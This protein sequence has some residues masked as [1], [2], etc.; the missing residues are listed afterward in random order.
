MQLCKA[1]AVHDQEQS[2]KL[3]FA[4][5]TIPTPVNLCGRYICGTKDKTAT[6][7]LLV[8][9]V[10]VL[11]TSVGGFSRA[12]VRA[13][14][15]FHTR[16]LFFNIRTILKTPQRKHVSADKRQKI[17][18]IFFNRNT[19]LRTI[20]SSTLLQ[21][22]F[23]L[24]DAASAGPDTALFSSMESSSTSRLPGLELRQPVDGV[25]E[26]DVV[27]VIAS[28]DALVELGGQRG[29]LGLGRHERRELELGEDAAELL[30]RHG[31]VVHLVVVL[32]QREQ[33]H[34]V[35][36]NLPR[37]GQKSEQPVPRFSLALHN[38]FEFFEN[39]RMVVAVEEH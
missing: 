2:L 15:W 29:P 10:R 13:K 32:E 20:R 3:S 1:I 24:I 26:P 27:D 9:A 37:R 34:P 4:V 19:Y 6:C 12:N 36:P 17:M 38:A 7:K 14:I 35:L 5:Q 21:K 33:L 30:S 31:A 11:P 22:N 18:I 8:N 25:A 39:G 16:T 23:R 28:S